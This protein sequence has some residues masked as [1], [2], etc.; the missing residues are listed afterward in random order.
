[1]ETFPEFIKRRESSPIR[2]DPIIA[3]V[4]HKTT[5]F[6]VNMDGLTPEDRAFLNETMELRNDILKKSKIASPS[7]HENEEG[8]NKVELK[9]ITPRETQKVC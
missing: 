5:E 8:T 4:K 7:T 3:E 9:T 1:M 6:K 2:P